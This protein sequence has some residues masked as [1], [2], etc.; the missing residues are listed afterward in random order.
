MKEPE[1][2]ERTKRQKWMSVLAKADTELLD[3]LWC[4][5]Q[6]KPSWVN[7]R[8][9]ETGMVMVR[10]KAGGVGTTF[11][12]GEMALT[13]ATIRLDSGISGVA[14][15]QGRSALKAEQSAVLDAMLQDDRYSAAIFKKVIK[16]LEEATKKQKFS[17]GKKAANTKVE[18]F[19]MVRGE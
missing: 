3:T 17:A 5:L 9:P 11:N 7:V 6:D 18:F 15:V 16:P 14:Y 12:V 4:E 8:A 2:L 13:R 10:G 1:K 19:T